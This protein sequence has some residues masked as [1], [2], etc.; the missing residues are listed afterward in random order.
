MALLSHM[1]RLGSSDPVELRGSIDELIE[2]FDLSK[3]GSAPTKF[4]VEDLFPLTA[5]YLHTQPLSAVSSNLDDLGVPAALQEAFWRVIRE[6]ITVKG[7]LA[8]WWALCR[9][10]AEPWIDDEDKDFV[11]EAM[12]LLPGGPYTPETWSQWTSAVKEKTGRKGRGLFQPLRKALT[13][14]THGPDMGDL[15]PL[16]QVIKAKG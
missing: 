11:A 4:D 15:M 12:T 1:A 7:D 2:G 5:R 6:N 8:A 16:M 3:F 10:G 13:G 9:D 14:Q